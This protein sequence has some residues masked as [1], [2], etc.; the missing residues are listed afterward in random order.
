M[1]IT[2][3]RVFVMKKTPLM[4]IIPLLFFGSISVADSVDMRD[5]ILLSNGMSEAEVLYRLGPY[6]HETVATGYYNNILHK[7]W[8]YIPAPDEDSNRKWITEIRF[9]GNGRVIAR[10]RYRAR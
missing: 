2:L 6:D 5:Y 9:D 3:M 1:Q 4:T 8:Y 7:T 10:D